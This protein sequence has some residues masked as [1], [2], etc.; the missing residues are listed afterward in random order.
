MLPYLMLLLLL[1]MPVESVLAN[2]F[3]RRQAG[4]AAK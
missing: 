2:L 3:S 4:Q 1:M